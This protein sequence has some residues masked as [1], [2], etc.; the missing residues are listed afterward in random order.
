MEF[1]AKSLHDR[2]LVVLFMYKL[3]LGGKI[4]IN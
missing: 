4:F 1:V 2:T 3:N